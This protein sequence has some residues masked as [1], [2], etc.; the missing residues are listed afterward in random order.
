VN[1]QLH[2]GVDSISREAGPAA[3]PDRHSGKTPKMTAAIV[4]TTE[5]SSSHGA[6]KR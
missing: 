5:T 1:G 3:N 4:I 6:V 2:G